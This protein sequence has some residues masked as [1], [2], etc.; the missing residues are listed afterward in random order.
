[1]DQ[2][3]GE[4]ADLADQARDR[5]GGCGEGGDEADD[6]RFPRRD[7]TRNPQ[8]ERFD[9]GLRQAAEQDV[10]LRLVQQLNSGDCAE[11]FF[12]SDG[13]GVGVGCVIATP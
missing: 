9:D 8:K 12:E 11:A 10:R 3:L 5:G 6:A 4:V 1:L 13:H 7:R 2:L